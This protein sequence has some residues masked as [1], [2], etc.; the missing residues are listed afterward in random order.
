VP[1]HTVSEAAARAGVAPHV[2]RY[3][4]R[5]G[6]LRPGRNPANGYR[7]FSD[8]EVARLRFAR[9]AQAL[10]FSL[11][12]VRQILEAVSKI[13]RGPRCGRTA[14]QTR[15]HSDWHRSPA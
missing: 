11:A 3:Y 10:G 2:V 1:R 6:L 7:I 9:K 15:S 5:I 14:F 13:P 12:E 4:A 8:R